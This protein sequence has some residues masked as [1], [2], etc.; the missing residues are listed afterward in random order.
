MGK[1]SYV[2]GNTN[3]FI[4]NTGFHPTPTNGPVWPAFSHS[5]KLTADE[6]IP[7]TEKAPWLV[8]DTTL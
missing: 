5:T 8:L 4:Q 1:H 2:E 6:W 7:A 3:S